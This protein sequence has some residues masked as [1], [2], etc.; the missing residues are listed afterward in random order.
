MLYNKDDC[1]CHTLFSVLVG[2]SMPCLYHEELEVKEYLQGASMEELRNILAEMAR[3]SN[4]MDGLRNA[5]VALG[6]LREVEEADGRV[7]ER[8]ESTGILI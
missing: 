5:I 8:E 1:I 3:V 7:V 4:D 2:R 6:S